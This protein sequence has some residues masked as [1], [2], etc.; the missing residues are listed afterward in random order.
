MTCFHARRWSFDTQS[1]LVHFFTK[2]VPLRSFGSHVTWNSAVPDPNV[3]CCILL[4]LCTLDVGKYQNGTS[5]TRV[6]AR[7]KWTRLVLFGT[8][9]LNAAG[10]DRRVE[11]R[12]VP[13]RT[14]AISRCKTRKFG[15]GAF[16]YF[17][18]FRWNN[19]VFPGAEWAPRAP[20]ARTNSKK[21]HLT[22]KIS[23]STVRNRL[24]PRGAV[25]SLTIS[26]WSVGGSNPVKDVFQCCFFLFHFFVLFLYV[27]LE[28]SFVTDHIPTDNTAGNNFRLNFLLNK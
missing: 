5:Y 17:Y 10:E 13:L 1:V 28:S 27:R 2:Y 16:F 14:F 4:F 3:W 12:F 9:W 8:P 24:I 7:H 26:D 15:R 20:R 18:M 25:E 19:T 6:S 22:K 23:F 11:E 21:N